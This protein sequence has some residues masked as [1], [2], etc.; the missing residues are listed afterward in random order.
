MKKKPNSNIPRSRSLE[1]HIYNHQ[2]FV[3]AH[4]FL[5]HTPDW[6]PLTTSIFLLAWKWASTHIWL[7]A[8]TCISR[9]SRMRGDPLI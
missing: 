8:I 9:M 6:I 7:P 2:G 3:L 4:H 5:F 1:F